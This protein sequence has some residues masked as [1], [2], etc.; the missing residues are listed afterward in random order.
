MKKR[1]LIRF[2]IGILL[3]LTWAQTVSAQLDKLPPLDVATPEKTF[4]SPDKHY[5]VQIVQNP[6]D[7]AH[8]FLAEATIIVTRKGKCILKATTEGFLLNAFWSKDGNW[9]ALNN[10]NANSGD[11]VWAISLRTG[12]VIRKP[13]DGGLNVPESA[14]TKYPEYKNGGMYHQWVATSGFDDS[15]QLH[16][17]ES[18]TYRNDEENYLFIALAYKIEGEKLVLTHWEATKKPRQVP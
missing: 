6:E 12:K 10:R 13:F 7:A 11:Y 2:P 4:T 14:C 9:L 17:S 8:P 1:N 3:L 16:V 5:V 18:T 15:G